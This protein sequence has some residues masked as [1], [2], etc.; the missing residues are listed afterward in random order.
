MS[1]AAYPLYVLLTAKAGTNG[2]AIASSAA[3]TVYVVLLM[4]WLRRS[5]N[6]VSDDYGAF[7]LRALP[8]TA[9]GIGA[10]YALRPLVTTDLV[11]LRGTI[12]ASAAGAVF[13]A[14]ALLFRLNEARE[15][16]AML[17]RAVNRRLG[18]T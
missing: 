6:G 15:V 17:R 2:L 13:V 4:M 8:A 1:V 16:I 9:L 10:G 7:F 18:R 12:L 11:L 3:I 5:F 14:A